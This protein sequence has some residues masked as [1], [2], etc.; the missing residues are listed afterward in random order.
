MSQLGHWRRFDGLPTTSGLPRCTDILRV[1]PH[2]SRVPF[3]AVYA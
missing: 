1:G 3:A 2:V